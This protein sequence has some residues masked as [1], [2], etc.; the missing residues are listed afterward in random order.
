MAVDAK[1]HLHSLSVGSMIVAPPPSAPQ[2]PS[3]TT[4]A[5]TPVESCV[6]VNVLNEY[7]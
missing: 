7:D 6:T 3:T 5:A 4:V 1:L 2:L